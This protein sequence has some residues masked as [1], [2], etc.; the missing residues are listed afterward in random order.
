MQKAI[1]TFTNSAGVL[2]LAVATALFLLNWTTPPDC[3]PPHDPIFLMSVNELFWILGGIAAVIGWFCLFSE[4]LTIPS[5]LLF[6]FALNYVACRIGL[7]WYG[8][9]SFAGYLEGFSRTFGVSAATANLLADILFAYLLIGGSIA[10]R[11]S[12]R[13]P[14]PIVFQKMPCPSCGGRVKFPI[15]SLGKT[16]VCPHCKAS[17]TLRKAEELLRMDCFFCKE[18]IEFPAHALGR[19]IK[20]PHCKM[21]IGLKENL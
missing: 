4:R 8:C 14:T 11:L 21:E 16:V 9:R 6:W 5:L 12:W 19:K 10:L 17:V 18:H 3:V 2:L 7:R 1:T 15:E 20:C 13:L